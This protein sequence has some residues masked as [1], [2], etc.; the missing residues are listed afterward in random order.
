MKRAPSLIKNWKEADGGWEGR[1]SPSVH[2]V[3]KRNLDCSYSGVWEA[4]RR[5]AV[6]WL[7]AGLSVSWCYHGSIMRVSSLTLGRIGAFS[8]PSASINRVI[9]HI[10]LESVDKESLERPSAN[11]LRPPLIFLYFTDE[12]RLDGSVQFLQQRATRKTHTNKTLPIFLIKD[13]ITNATK[14]KKNNNNSSWAWSIR[15]RWVWPITIR[16]W[17]QLSKM[18][19]NPDQ[20]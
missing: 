7:A 3:S 5:E 20:H 19:L 10:S 13:D 18:Q 16:I 6:S 4:R 8:P 17:L 15:S 14:K 12:L 11:H 2:S 9:E 1:E